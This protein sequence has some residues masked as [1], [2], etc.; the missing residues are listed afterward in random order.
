[1]ECVCEGEERESVC[2]LWSH[3]NLYVCICLCIRVTIS[4]HFIV[5]PLISFDSDLQL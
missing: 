2:L 4:I 5:L 1:M 3:V